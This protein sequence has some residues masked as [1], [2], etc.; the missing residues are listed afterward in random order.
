MDANTISLN[1]Y[2]E[3][4]EKRERFLSEFILYVNMEE[5]ESLINNAKELAKNYKGYDFTEDLEDMI[6]EI[7]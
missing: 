4:Q 7:I 5:V 1:K 6:K 2:L 3:E